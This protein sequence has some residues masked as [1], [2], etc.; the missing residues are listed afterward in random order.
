MAKQRQTASFLRQR[1]QE[2]GINPVTKLG[3]N[4][5]ID[6]NLVELLVR[7]AQLEPHD[8]VLEVGTGT[9]SLTGMMAEQAAHIVTV[10]LD[11]QMYQLASEELIDADNVTLLNQD[12]LRNKNNLHDNVIQLIQDR[13]AV[14]DG[15]R[16]KLVAN[17]PYNVATPILSNL[18]L[19]PIVPARMVVTIQKEL[20][21]RIVAH[22]QTKDYGSLS[23]WIQSQC[24]A[25]IVRVMP[26]NVFWPR[27]KVDSAIIS[28]VLSDEKRAQIPDLPM[29]QTFVRAMFFHRR[30][31]LR[32]VM[33]SAFKQELK[34][35][36]ID[37]IMGRMELGPNTRTEQL[38]VERI[39][40]LYECTREELRS[41]GQLT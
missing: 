24:A 33:V 32:S 4:F 14:V 19:T 10:E 21:D 29:F 26:P 23:V 1:F 36:N 11:R 7:S 13:L 27:P 15:G 41:V 34:K 22:P 38:S 5:L 17:L 20:A 3:Q 2:V 40:A 12:V 39:L 8:V 18:L 9:G 31:F 30:K 16:F 37:A 35:P 25:E 28:I 6:L